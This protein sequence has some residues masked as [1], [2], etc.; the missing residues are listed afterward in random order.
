MGRQPWIVAPNPTG[1][2][3]IRLSVRSAVSPFVDAPTVAISLVVFT[4]LYGVPGGGLV[5][6]DPPVRPHRRP[7]HPHRLRRHR[8]RCTVPAAGGTGE[9]ADGPLTFAY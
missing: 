9:D 2:H 1:D 4:L 5:R 6:A 8:H 3:A 7:R